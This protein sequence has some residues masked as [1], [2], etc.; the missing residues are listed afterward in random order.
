MSRTVLVT[1]ASSGIGLETV[2]R[3][4]ARDYTVIGIA[5][6]FSKSALASER[7]IP[8]NLDLADTKQLPAQFTALAKDHPGVTDIVCCAGYGRFGD[9]ETFSYDQITRLMD[10][11]F[12]AHCF[13]VKALIPRLKQS[14]RA[15]IVFIGSES[16]L[17]GGK[18]GSVYCASKFALRGFAQSLRHECSRANVRVTLINP[19]M[20]KTAFFDELSFQPGEDEANYIEPG[21]VADA[22]MLALD[23]RGASVVDEINLSPMKNVV[24]KKT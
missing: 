6:D 18:Q 8:I 24:R 17:S 10:V 11:N 14:K 2:K 4:L 7:F 19:G 15:D 20:V 16:A 22:I 9:L 13:L 5:R 1:G 3:L 23:M 12:T 21:D